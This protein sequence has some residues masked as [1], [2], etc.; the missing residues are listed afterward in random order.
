MPGLRLPRNVVPLAYDAQLHV[1]PAS[2]TFSGTIDITVRVLEPT[3]LVWLNAKKLAIR[4][5]QAAALR[6]RRTSDRRRRVVPGSDDVVGLSFAKVLP[7]GE[8]RLSLVF[9]GVD[10]R[11]RAPIGLFRQQEGDRWYAV[12]QF[13]PHGRAA[14]VSVLRR[15][16]P[17]GDV[18]A[19]A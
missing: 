17:Q 12:T 18:E 3:D 11:R 19:D 8:V 1:D 13:E 4:D 6:A 7:A 16:G 5:A 10:R 9:I 15:A 14:R 2:D